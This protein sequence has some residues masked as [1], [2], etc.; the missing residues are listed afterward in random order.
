MKRNIIDKIADF[1]SP[2]WALDRLRAR[3]TTDQVTGLVAELEEKRGYEGAALGRRTANWRTTPAG[4]NTEN[5]SALRT[6]R[7]RSRDLVRN[8]PYAKK[9]VQVIGSNVVG[10][11]IKAAADLP[12][13]RAK[14]INAA[15]NKWANSPACDFDGQRNLYGVQRAVMRAVVESGEALVVRKRLAPDEAK[16]YAG[17]GIQL[18]I[19]EGD[20][21]DSGRD[22]MLAEGGGRIVQ[23]VEF[24]A[25]GRRVAYWLFKSHPGEN[26]LWGDRTSVR[27]PAEDVLHIYEVLRPGQ[28]RGIP[29]GVSAMLRL[30]DYDEYEDAQLIR[31]KI[32]ACYAVFYNG[33]EQLGS[34]QQEKENQGNLP[35]QIEPGTIEKLPAG[36]SVTIASPPPVIGYGE[37]SKAVLQ[38]VA[39]AYGVTYEQITG[40]YSNVN[41]SSARMAR[42]EFGSYVSELQE[43]LVVQFCAKVWDWFA[44]SSFLVGTTSELG[45][46]ANWTVPARTM[47]DPA[48]EIK[49]IKEAVRAGFMSWSDAVLSL[50]YVP[51]DLREAIKSD[52][53]AADSAKLQLTSDPRIF[54]D[55]GALLEVPAPPAPKPA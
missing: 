10:T 30:R 33:T 24:D 54:N 37:Y 36:S 39:A 28:V 17:L 29:F 5:R 49:A 9:A 48:K 40:D 52:N 1:V 34:L 35:N 4:V 6:L 11:G 21:L 12:T 15:W 51:E 43:M 55:Q 46:A 26:T 38:A 41:Y 23:G 42:L 44:L 18:Q 22:Y 47:I 19:L 53:K 20:Y 31:Q 27:I 3:V 50:G 25:T 45:I 32:A 14:K 7:D 2:S 8:N 13:G 16:K